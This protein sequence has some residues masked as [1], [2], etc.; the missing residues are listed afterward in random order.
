MSEPVV[1]REQIAQ[2]VRH[3]ITLGTEH[4]NPYPRESDAHAAWVATVER[5]RNEETQ[6][7]GS[8]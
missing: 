3:A 1:T 8:A 5:L 4:V 6:G 2:Q 7:E